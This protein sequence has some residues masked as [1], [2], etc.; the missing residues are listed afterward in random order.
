MSSLATRQLLTITVSYWETLHNPCPVL[1][2]VGLNPGPSGIS[3]LLPF[4]WLHSLPLYA[5]PY[6]SPSDGMVPWHPGAGTGPCSGTACPWE[7]VQH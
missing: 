3:E 7:G 6:L 4:G 5:L 1:D 2:K